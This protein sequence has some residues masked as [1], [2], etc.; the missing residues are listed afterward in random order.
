MYTSFVGGGDATAAAAAA[1]QN[2]SAAK[3]T[4]AA[5][6]AADARARGLSTVR[7]EKCG[8]NNLSNLDCYLR[9]V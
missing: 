1:A 8:V 5:A 6:A 7:I 4:A 3:P 9:G 2:G